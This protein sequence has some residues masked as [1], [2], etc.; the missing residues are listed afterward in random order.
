[1]ASTLAASRRRP[2]GAL[3][4]PLVG[5]LARFLLWGSLTFL[6]VMVIWNTIP[7]FADGNENV[8]FLE[9]APISHETLWRVCFWVHI[10]GGLICLV[11]ALPLFHRG[12]LRRHPDLQR[13]ALSG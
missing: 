9:K 13:G 12:L 6:T 10:S 5:A 8:F 4:A 2:L 3:L 11:A 7:H 1:M